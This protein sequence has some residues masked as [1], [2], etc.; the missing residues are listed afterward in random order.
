MGTMSHQIVD[1]LQDVNK[2]KTQEGQ[3]TIKENVF[4]NGGDTLICLIA[5]FINLLENLD[6]AVRLNIY[7]QRRYNVDWNQLKEEAKKIGARILSDAVIMKLPYNVH[8]DV[9]TILLKADGNI[10]VTFIEN[11]C[12]VIRDLSFNRTPDQMLAIMKALQ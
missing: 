4:L 10:R 1:G 9:D 3:E 12:V 6:W 8:K 2:S 11:D 7:Y 5:G